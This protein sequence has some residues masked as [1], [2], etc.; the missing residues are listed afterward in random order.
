MPLHFTCSRCGAWFSLFP[1]ELRKRP[2]PFCSRQC[3][4]ATGIDRRPTA[5]RFWEKVDRSGDCWIW[6]ASLLAGYGQAFAQEFH[7][8]RAMP[9]HRV[10]W[11]LATG[12]VPTRG[13]TVL[14]TC[15][16]RPCVRNDEEGWYP[17]GTMLLPRRGHLAL[18]RPIHNSRDMAAK[19]R[20]STFV[21][22]AEKVPRGER[23]G[24]AR[25]APADVVAIRALSE[26]GASHAVLSRQFGISRSHVSALVRR[27]FWKHLP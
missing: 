17:V 19:G 25:L 3:R 10:A 24:Q 1:S 15:D 7:A 22:P 14:H 12:H 23:N 21:V 11:F 2:G 16:N 8:K 9:A 13:E 6:T 4:V 20:A 18:G 5:D 27:T 26:N